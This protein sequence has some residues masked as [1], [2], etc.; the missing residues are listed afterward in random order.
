L[1][2]GIVLIGYFGTVYAIDRLGTGTADSINE[3]AKM[4]MIRYDLSHAALREPLKIKKSG[5]E[6]VI[7][8][9]S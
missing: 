7:G 8:K 5:L 6:Q 3:E 2:A 4:N 1:N 9:D